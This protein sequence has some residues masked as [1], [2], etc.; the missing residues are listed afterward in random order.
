MDKELAV[1]LSPEI[2]GQWLNVWVEIGDKWHPPG[3]KCTLS[4]FADDTKLW[5][6]STHHRDGMLSRGT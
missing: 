4:K 5:G 2:G 6:A 1:G 3:V